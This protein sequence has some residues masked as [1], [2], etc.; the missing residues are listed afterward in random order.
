[1][2]WYRF[3][4]DHGPGHQSHS[5]R[6]VWLT[7]KEQFQP[8]TKKLLEGLWEDEFQNRDFAVGDVEKVKAPPEKVRSF[9]L[10]TERN[11]LERCRRMI[12]LLEKGIK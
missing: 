6:Y 4:A 10:A 11:K 8:I 2:A 9:M 7:A 3:W 5:E 1:M 12:V